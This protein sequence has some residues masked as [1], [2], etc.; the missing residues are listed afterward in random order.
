MWDWLTLTCQ[1]W[2]V[3]RKQRA[4]STTDVNREAGCRVA[5]TP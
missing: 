5:N 1:L 3:P 2:F 4:A